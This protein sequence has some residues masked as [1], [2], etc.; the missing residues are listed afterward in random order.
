MSWDP[1]PCILSTFKAQ[2]HTGVSYHVLC[3]NDHHDHVCLTKRRLM[4]PE[5]AGYGLA[6]RE[7]KF[8][9]DLLDAEPKFIS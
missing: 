4:I 5:F 1:K 6:E 2:T 8:A 9:S 3:C 7:P